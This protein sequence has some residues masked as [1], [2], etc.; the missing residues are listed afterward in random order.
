M[1]AKRESIGKN[2]LSEDEQLRTMVRSA[3]QEAPTATAVAEEKPVHRTG[4]YLTEEEVEALR[5]AAYQQRRTK[6]DLIRSAIRCDFLF[7]AS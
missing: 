3:T 1:S 6:T 4:V 7:L 5:D 2:P